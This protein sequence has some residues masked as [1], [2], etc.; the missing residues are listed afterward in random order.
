MESG[1]QVRNVAVLLAGGVGTRV[2]LDIPGALAGPLG[3]L[4]IVYGLTHAANLVSLGKDKT[5]TNPLAV[6]VEP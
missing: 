3:L 5:W 1:S 4:S 6:T 2:G